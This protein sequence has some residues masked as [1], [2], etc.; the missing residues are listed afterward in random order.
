VFDASDRVVDLNP[1]ARRAIGHMT[2]DVVGKPVTQVFSNWP[3]LIE[4][5][6]DVDQ[7]HTEIALE[8]PDGRRY[9]DL[10]ITPLR[11]RSGQHTGRIVVVRDITELRVAN[12]RLQALSRLKDEF[13]SNVSHELRTP[14]TNIKLHLDLLAGNPKKTEANLATLQRETARLARIIEDLL[15]LSRLDQGKMEIRITSIDCNALADQ[16]VIDRQPLAGRN[17]QTL[18]FAGHQDLPAVRG[19]EGLLGQ[20]LSILLTNA[21]NYTPR[22]EQ[23]VVSTHL[24]EKAGERWVGFRVSDTG[25]GIPP[26][27]HKQ[28]FER[29]FRG[30]TGHE[31]GVPGTGLGLAVVQ[32][33]AERHG[34]V[35][36]V[37]SEGVPGKGA[38]FSVWLPAN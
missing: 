16:Y 36:E 23:V 19:D 29:F 22:G 18:T 14:I 5:L 27:E 28:L 12:E 20:A 8:E 32:E 37:V 31:S 24:R 3:R 9:F 30:K 38:A 33:I 15:Y 2:A 25:P 6:Q 34:G 21:L 1:A 7:T 17:G 35:V 26:D 11:S 4:Q 10:R 13:V